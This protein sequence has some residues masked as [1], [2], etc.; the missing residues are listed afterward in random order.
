[1][2]V[3]AQ[4]SSEISQTSEEQ[5]QDQQTVQAD[6]AVTPVADSSSELTPADQVGL[7]Q[8]ES[9]EVS[10]ERARELIAERFGEQQAEQVE[11]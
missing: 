6:S 10:E 11:Q 7:A 2:T 4:S 3:L 9:E 8:V 1:M 5:Q